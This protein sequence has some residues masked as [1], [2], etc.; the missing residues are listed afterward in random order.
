MGGVEQQCTSRICP[1]IRSGD[2]RSTAGSSKLVAGCWCAVSLRKDCGYDS[3]LPTG[4]SSSQ[5]S[6]VVDDIMVD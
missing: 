1:A 2:K 5:E 6:F 3:V 4:F